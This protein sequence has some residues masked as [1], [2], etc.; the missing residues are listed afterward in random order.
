MIVVDTSALIAIALDEPVAA[1]CI[2]ALDEADALLISAATLTETLI[3]AARRGM[4]TDTASLLGGLDLLVVPLDERRARAAARA[5]QRWGKGFHPASLG[6][7]DVFAYALA[8]EHDC[9]L[10]FV[11]DDFARTDVASALG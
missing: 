1:G 7:G 9:P 3:V 5:Y 11:G 8:K 10:L 2:V 4:G 6:Y